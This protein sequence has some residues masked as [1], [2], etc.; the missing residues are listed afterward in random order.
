[1]MSQLV[2]KCRNGLWACPVDSVYG[3]K[4]WCADNDFKTGKLNSAF[5]FRLKPGAKIYSIHTLDDLERISTLEDDMGYKGIDFP[6]LLHNG[7]DGIYASDEAVNAFHMYASENVKD[8]NAWDIESLCVFNPD[9]II[10]V[11]YGNDA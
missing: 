3:W 10:P 6:W 1:M 9:V 2:N 7:Y 5:Y 4:E 11:D 8:M